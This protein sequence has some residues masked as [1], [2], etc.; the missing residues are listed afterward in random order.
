[1]DEIVTSKRDDLAHAKQDRDAFRA[2]NLR[3]RQKSGILG[4]DVLLRDYEYRKVRNMC[5]TVLT[6]QKDEVDV[7]KTNL[8]SLK[9]KQSALTKNAWQ[10]KR[11]ILKVQSNS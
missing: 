11:K 8:E 9:D 1:M 2:D 6:I 4:N 5:G 10:Y 7:L 3:L